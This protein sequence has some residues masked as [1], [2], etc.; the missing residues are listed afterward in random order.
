MFG[1]EWTEGCPSCFFWADT[2]DGPMVHLGRRDLTMLCV[3]RAPLEKL[4][5]YKRR[6]GWSF[7][8][9]EYNFRW[10]DEP[11]DEELPGLSSFALEDGVALE[12]LPPGATPLLARSH[13]VRCHPFAS[14]GVVF[15][16]AGVR[17]P[18]STP[19]TNG[20]REIDRPELGG[21][22]L[23]RCSGASPAK[24]SWL[25]PRPHAWYC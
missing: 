14:F 11:W 7:H 3:S 15:P 24:P 10:V 16:V 8:G 18:R 4:Q 5:A 19:T 9:A 21:A 12:Q 23:D 17:G 20:W 25:S 13:L 22:G 2:F 6:M 1:P